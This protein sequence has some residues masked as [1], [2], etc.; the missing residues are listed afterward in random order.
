MTQTSSRPQRIGIFGGSFNPIHKGHLLAIERFL[1]SLDLDKVVLVPTGYSFY[2]QDRS[3]SFEDRF[4]MCKLAVESVPGVE[5]CDIERNQKQGMYS[6]DMVKGIREKYPHAHLF[7]LMGGDVFEHICLWK[8]IHV[9]AQSVDFAVIERNGEDRAQT[10][11]RITQAV[12]DYLKFFGAQTYFVDIGKEM[13]STDIRERIR[14]NLPTDE[15]LT[16]S[17][18]GYIRV[19]D[20]YASMEPRKEVKEKWQL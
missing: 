11:K 7:F 18:A 15:Y 5:V 6:C 8:G 19:G 3:V 14:R 20:L 1:V 2:K 17:V 9:L 16:E 4:R 10:H 12:A 13:S